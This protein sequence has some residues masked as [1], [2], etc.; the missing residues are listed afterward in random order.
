MAEESEVEQTRDT[1]SNAE[2]LLKAFLPLAMAKGLSFCRYADEQQLTAK[3]KLVHGAKGVEGHHELLLALKRIQPNLSFT[4]LAVHKALELLL[5][6]ESIQKD[7]RFKMTEDDKRDWQ[8]VMKRRVRNMCRVVT[9]GER[10]ADNTG[11]PVKWVANLPWNASNASAAA[12]T[13]T[14][15]TAPGAGSSTRTTAEATPSE[16]AT[17]PTTAT[18]TTPTE[19]HCHCLSS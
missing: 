11:K 16:A 18:P 7:I 5:Q 15:T 9:Q 14:A 1:C 17:A 2:E 19:R 12:P 3:A 10:K 13:T 4:K 6:E 8:T